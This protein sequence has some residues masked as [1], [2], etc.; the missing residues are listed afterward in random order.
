[1]INTTIGDTIL[2]ESCRYTFYY[3]EEVKEFMKLT[4]FR[5]NFIDILTNGHGSTLRV[6]NYDDEN[7]A[8]SNTECVYSMPIHF[9]ERVE[10]CDENPL[11]LEEIKIR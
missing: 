1:M 8:C 5:A 3:T 11:S 9:V 4:K 6:D 2:Q 7:G 10:C